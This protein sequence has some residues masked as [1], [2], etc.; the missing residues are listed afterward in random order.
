MPRP[1]LSELL[2]ITY[3]RIPLLAIGRDI[4]AD[5][6]L[7]IAELSRRFPE[8]IQDQTLGPDP[9]AGVLTKFLDDWS[10]EIFTSAIKL[11]PKDLP[12]MKDPKFL[13]DRADFAGGVRAQLSLAVQFG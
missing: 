12:L 5:T 1:D 7:I 13:K 4:F 6:R 3:R 9:S 8:A 2:G 10:D 11:L